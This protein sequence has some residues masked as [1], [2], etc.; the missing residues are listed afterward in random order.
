MNIAALDPGRE[1]CGFAVLAGDGHTLWQKVIET[2]TLEQVVE[3]TRAAYAFGTLI[4][5]NGT[6]SRQAGERLASRFPDL[7]VETI[8]EYRT[9]ELARDYY[10]ADNPPKGLKRLL[11]LGLQT[12]PVPVDDYAAVILGRRWIQSQGKLAADLPHV[13]EKLQPRV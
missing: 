11:P 8:D 9:T 10:W 2:A 13:P 4:K 6:T 12:P 7:T 3:E 1:K 5:G